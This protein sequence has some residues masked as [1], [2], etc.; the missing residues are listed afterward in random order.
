MPASAA[1]GHPADAKHLLASAGIFKMQGVGMVGRGIELEDGG[2]T[3]MSIEG[4][5]SDLVEVFLRQPVHEQPRSLVY[6]GSGGAVVL[7]QSYHRIRSELERRRGEV[8]PPQRLILVARSV[9]EIDDAERTLDDVPHEVL[10][11]AARSPA[12]VVVGLQVRGVLGSKAL[13]CADVISRADVA[14]S[15]TTASDE[16][17]GFSSPQGYAKGTRSPPQLRPD[18]LLLSAARAGLFPR[19]GSLKFC[20]RDGRDADAIILS[21]E[22]RHYRVHFAELKELDALQRLEQ[23]CWE[24]QLQTE[25]AEIKQRIASYP[26]GQLV[27]KLGD[28]VTGVVY[29]Q[30]IGNAADLNGVNCA[31]VSRLHKR[32]APIAQ[33]L[34][35]NIHPSA[36]DAGLG[37]QLLDFALAVSAARNCEKALAVS[38]CRDFHRQN[39]APLESYIRLKDRQG[40]L[41]D[42]IL[43]FHQEHG[44]TIAGLVQNYRPADVRNHG[45]GVLVEYDLSRLHE[46]C[47]EHR[48]ST[49]PSI[50]HDFNHLQLSLEGT[51]RS[52]KQGSA[53]DAI[54]PDRT[55]SDLD[56]D[57]LDLMQLRAS[58]QTRLGL[59]LD[60][61]IFFRYPTPRA[62]AGFLAQIGC[63]R[64]SSNSASL[65]SGADGARTTARHLGDTAA[66]ET[67]RDGS[68]AIIG[69]GC[70]FP[71]G[72][73][74]PDALWHVLHAGTD[75][76]TAFPEKRRL[77]SELGDDVGRYG[78]FLDDVDLFDASFFGIAPPEARYMDPQQRLLLETAWEAL[79]NA[80]LD[81]DALASKS[82]GV[83][84]GAFTRD[85]E[86]L[87]VKQSGTRPIGPYFGS[88]NSVSMLAGRLAYRLGLR[89]PALV[90]DTACSSSLVALHLARQSLR[91]RE[92]DIAIV[93]G[94][95]LILSPEWTTTFARA[96]M[97]AP[98]GRCKTFDTDANGYVRGE[99]CGVI[100]VERLDD[101]VDD[102][103]RILSVVRGTAVNQ[104]GASNGLTAPNEDAQVALIEAALA[105]AAVRPS[106]VSYV[107]AH[108]TGTLL[109]DPIEINALAR[110]YGKER[111]SDQ[112]L[113]IGSVKTNI[114]HLEATAGIAG[115]IKVI[116]ALQHETIPAHLHFRTP[117]PLI[118]LARIPAKVPTAPM[119]WPRA[120]DTV[121]LAAVSAFGFSGTNAHV[122][123]EEPPVSSP[124]VAAI[125]RPLHVLALSAA[126]DG[127]L[128]ELTERYRQ[129]AADSDADLA[130]LCYSANVGRKHFKHR[131]AVL[132]SSLGELRER[133]AESETRPGSVFAGVAPEQKGRP[134]FL[135]TGQ[136]SQFFGMCEEL[137][138]THPLV[139]RVLDRCDELLS[140][141]LPRSLLDVLFLDPSAAREL[142]ETRYTQPA[143]FSVQ[144]ALTALWESWGIEPAAVLGH[145]VG[146][147]SAACAA[148]VFSFEQGLR[149]VAGRARL[150]QQMPRGAMT[151]VHA[152]A[153][154]AREIAATSGINVDVASINGPED[155]VV[156]G[157]SA[158]IAEFE[159][160]LESRSLAYT[161]LRVS[162]ANH[163]SLLDPMLEDFAKLAEEVH[164]AA[165]RIP[166]VSSV[167]GAFEDVQLANP[168]YWV[169]QTR[170]AVIFAEAMRTCDR[171]DFSIFLEVGPQPVLSTLWRSAYPDEK[172][173]WLAS[174]GRDRSDWKMLLASVAELYL[175]GSPIDWQQF[176]A[177]YRRRRIAAPTYPFQRKRYWFTETAGT[178]A[179]QLLPTREPRMKTMAASP[180]Q[181][182]SLEDYY[183]S[184]EARIRQDSHGQPIGGGLIRFAPFETPVAGFTWIPT[185]L[186]LP[187]PIHHE[188][189]VQTA[190]RQMNDVLFHGVDFRSVSK[191]LD[192]GCGYATDLIALAAKYPHLTLHGHNISGE[193]IRYAR[194]RIDALGCGDRVKLF[195]L[196][197][198]KD[199]FTDVYD[200]AFSFQV[201]HHMQRKEGVF[202]NLGR[203]LCNGGY[204]FLAEIM[205]SGEPINHPESS[206]YFL[207]R[208][209]WAT[210]LARNSLKIVSCVDASP[211]IANYLLDLEFEANLAR[212][213]ADA[214]VNTR[215][216]LR[217]PEDLGRL[218]RKDFV[219]Y[220]L[221]TVQKDAFA[222]QEAIL[223]WNRMHL[224]H[225]IPYRWVLTFSRADATRAA[226]SSPLS[227]Q[228]ASAAS[229][230][231]K[232]S[233]PHSG[234]LQPSSLPAGTS[235]SDIGSILQGMLT[236]ILEI[237]ASQLD[238]QE[239]LVHL[240]LNS[241][242]AM[243]VRRDMK[244]VM[245]VSID[246]RALLSGWSFKDLVNACRLNERDPAAEGTGRDPA[247]GT[248]GGKPDLGTPAQLLEQLPYLHEKD[249]DALLRDLTADQ[250]TRIS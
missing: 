215:R 122:I 134:L 86:L 113:V 69:L 194:R 214:D 188:A 16:M 102:G 128:I 174:L 115:L 98:D 220:C 192:I 155:V 164:F 203:F 150:M 135:F 24:P 28:R 5:V 73:N 182:H 23:A 77:D 78:G 44:A 9:P 141:E 94:V 208:S 136:G 114:G 139:K 124:D 50:A 101:A 197:S 92:C 140:D 157:A 112:P 189:L 151:A 202:A 108:G 185:F 227:P 119:P 143:M 187:L 230:L 30:R 57:S 175:R 196:D 117:N 67:N 239:S 228:A 176:D 85:Y 121:R 62:L 223:D 216:H 161:R 212:F 224:Y 100:C 20:R 40:Y 198:A 147:Y 70:R 63:E 201:I 173:L 146:E 137:Y 66:R 83:F 105:E 158:A 191:V 234:A 160:H 142:D 199:D 35:I 152:A 3:V 167:T 111:A 138:R 221:V 153:E 84:V 2:C 14:A 246:L 61:T 248:T 149:L 19:K 231:A 56:F 240:G 207:P 190:Q 247:I 218:L 39:Q 177:P 103:H 18:E 11:D 68:L 145:S 109:G 180:A 204:L 166:V 1:L 38:L 87:Q 8:S 169:R 236:R 222:A 148:G 75:T 144:Y 17:N 27:L 59:D 154:Q 88:G 22:E 242:M 71:G 168:A 55:F 237:D 229:V 156:S 200:L 15:F 133:L 163:S 64:K 132:A 131:K 232:R 97:L 209:D 184:L 48:P 183:G 226:L 172:K 12:D 205:A 243:E 74:G 130:D 60:P 13:I 213:A 118:D 90:V 37:D 49:V 125:D 162:H 58:L 4:L 195:E 43:R 25:L 99:G 225:R 241:L 51:I 6:V 91:S 193:Q 171:E 245:G 82:V 235:G 29:S 129:R 244:R 31:D 79:E 41:V 170:E 47:R 10:L 116:L 34:A 206:A 210:V 76:I 233:E 80:A 219:N 52:I 107:E 165:P 120:G 95:N 106:Q 178:R 238:H 123:V 42:P 36:Q 93:A 45:H 250:A 126:T 104:D 159:S 7:K 26:E 21:F 127:A 211:E 46:H 249:I 72:G 33:L 217:G 110:V 181:N 89:G 65:S 179:G 53:P 32:H 96:G 54:D 186:G 81:P